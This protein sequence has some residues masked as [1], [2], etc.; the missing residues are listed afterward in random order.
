MVIKVFFERTI[1]KIIKFL[2][3]YHMKDYIIKWDEKIKLK[4]EGTKDDSTDKD[5]F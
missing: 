5:S 2:N 3:G 1:E 4:N